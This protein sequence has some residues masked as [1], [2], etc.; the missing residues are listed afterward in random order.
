MMYLGTVS[1]LIIPT[2]WANYKFQKQNLHLKTKVLS[3][4]SSNTRLRVSPDA[5]NYGFSP[6]KAENQCAGYSL[7]LGSSALWLPV[8]NSMWDAGQC[9]RT[10]VSSSQRTH[11]KLCVLP[12]RLSL[13][14]LLSSL[15]FGPQ[16]LFFS[17]FPSP[18]WTPLGTGR[19]GWVTSRSN[20]KNNRSGSWAWK[21]DGTSKIQSD[22]WDSAFHIVLSL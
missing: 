9:P 17:L 8:C 21:A 10:S 18:E 22:K 7:C 13:R 11:W 1:T 16:T 5:F 3:F 14:T 15:N 20:H 12:C 4:P 6:L 2:W 19:Q